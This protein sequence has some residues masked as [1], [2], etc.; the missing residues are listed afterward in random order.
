MPFG[1][2]GVISGAASCFYGF[3]G[4]DCV[5]TTGEE[6]K[7]PQRDIPI[8]IVISLFIIFLGYFGVSVVLTMMWPYYLQV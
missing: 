3:V 1:V 6:A 4:F 8:A 7:N 2:A 5:A